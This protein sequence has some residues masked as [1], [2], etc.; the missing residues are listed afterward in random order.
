MEYALG[1]AMSVAQEITRRNKVR[2]MLIVTDC[3]AHFYFPAFATSGES[4][5]RAAITGLFLY[6]QMCDS[7]G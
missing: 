2:L 3:C 6:A 7:P 4:I 1:I 5:P